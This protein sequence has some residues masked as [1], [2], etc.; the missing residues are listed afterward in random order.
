M[1]VGK[2]REYSTPAQDK[3]SQHEVKYCGK[4]ERD[5]PIGEFAKRSSTTCGYASWC[6]VCSRLYDHDNRERFR[7]RKAY[8][9]IKLMYGLGKELYD[10]LVHKQNNKCAIC[11]VEFGT[12]RWTKPRVDH[13]HTAPHNVR[14][15]LCNQCNIGLGHFQDSR[16]LLY[17]AWIYLGGNNGQ[18]ETSSSP[19]G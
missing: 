13:E 3:I 9:W 17:K 7:E 1:R 10:A 6:K 12:G 11:G 14:G 8:A 5:K 16:D 18:T 19:G 4:C 2:Y 15:L